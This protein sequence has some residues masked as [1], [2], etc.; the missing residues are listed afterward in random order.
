VNRCEDGALG[1]QK[2]LWNHVNSPRAM[3]VYITKY[4]LTI[5][6]IGVHLTLHLSLCANVA[7]HQSLSLQP[8][9]PSLALEA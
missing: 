4:L 9:E 5:S 8:V 6:I 1:D 3:I 7:A 2:V